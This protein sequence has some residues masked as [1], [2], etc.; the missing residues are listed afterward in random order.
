MHDIAYQI[1]AAHGA[2]PTAALHAADHLHR[3]HH[4]PRD[5][6]TTVIAY[7]F[8]TKDQTIDGQ[9]T[10]NPLSRL[11]AAPAYAATII[12]AALQPQHE[13]ARALARAERQAALARAT[14]AIAAC[15]LCD[16]HGKRHGRR[17]SHSTAEEAR[18]DTQREERAAAAAA[19][20]RE[21]RAALANHDTQESA[22]A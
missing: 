10:R 1:A 15:E 2:D 3:T 18:R 5:Q 16:A 4:V 13:E 8:Q 14:E 9:T 22:T 7:A 12:A 6:I 17:C 11:R 20:L 19:G 21:V